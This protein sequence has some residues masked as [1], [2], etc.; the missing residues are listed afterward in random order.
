MENAPEDEDEEGLPSD[1]RE[2]SL[3]LFDDEEWV[4]AVP[5]TAWAAWWWGQYSQWCTAHEPGSFG[6]YQAKGPLVVF[7]SRSEGDSW[8]LHPATGEFRDERNRLVSWRGFLSRNPSIMAAIIG[9][10]ARACPTPSASVMGEM[11]SGA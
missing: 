10:L 7:C 11:G 1:V 6:K 8:Q 3:L 5:M 2:Q 4:V 9:V